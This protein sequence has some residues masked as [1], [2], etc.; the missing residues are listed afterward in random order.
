ML[1]AIVASAADTCACEV[2]SVLNSTA[3]TVAAETSDHPHL[4]HED[5][6]PEC[7]DRI[8]RTLLR[9][10]KNHATQFGILIGGIGRLNDEVQQ[11]SGCW[12]NNNDNQANHQGCGDHKRLFPPVS[13]DIDHAMVESASTELKDVFPLPPQCE[14]PLPSEQEVQDPESTIPPAMF[15]VK[16]STA[17]G[18]SSFRTDE[19]LSKAKVARIS[20]SG[21]LDG[22]TSQLTSR[23]GRARYRARKVVRS[24]YFDS[25]LGVLVLVNAVTVGA[26]LNNGDSHAL[27]AHLRMIEDLILLV[28][29]WE[30]LLRIFADGVH[31]FRDELVVF[32]AV[33]ALAGI[34]AHVLD[35]LRH[36]TAFGERI[37]LGTLS[38]IKLVRLLRLV[39][40]LRLVAL[41]EV[42]SQLVNSM[43]HACRGLG[44]VLVLISLL[45]YIFSCLSLELI[46][47]DPTF[48]HDQEIQESFMN[49]PRAML[50]L[51]AFVT[52]DGMSDIYLPVVLRKPS[53]IVYFICL[54][55]VMSIS[56]VN[57][58]TGYVLQ[59]S[60]AMTTSDKLMDKRLIKRR[61]KHL[62]PEIHR[63]FRSLDIT[64]GGRIT[65]DDLVSATHVLP[66][67]LTDLFNADTM[68]ELFEF[69]DDDN[70]GSISLKEFEEN[71]TEHTIRQDQ[72]QDYRV[73][74]LLRLQ[75]RRIR[76]LAGSVEKL[77][78]LN[79]VWL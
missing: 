34:T 52:L 35:L 14:R 39:R 7:L 42:L 1:D 59:S 54:I 11:L 28:F 66:K 19:T 40:A 50:T 75:S 15:G 41:F 53:L 38:V 46:R 51:F 76:E 61:I 4:R 58:V 56:L 29:I 27:D 48:E 79:P 22:N 63:A 16:Q 31:V 24:E 77:H 36:V 44:S 8:S 73:M 30:I 26:R 18:F 21:T 2:P 43:L 3:E 12:S 5:F 70:S 25:V 9:M 17:T 23:L 62:T 64:G 6:G 13:Q 72:E 68:L 65:K 33:I 10:E 47:D 20:S 57:I 49:L 67:V 32:D 60:I 45:M 69:L 55:L 71:I 37:S 74:R 78:D